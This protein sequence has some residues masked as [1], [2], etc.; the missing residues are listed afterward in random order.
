MSIKAILFDFDGTLANTLPLC[1]DAFRLSIEPLAGRAISNREIIATFGPSEE[2]TIRA[3]V[4]D[5]YDEGV[6]SYL[7]HYE[8][9]H[10]Q[11]TDIFP[12]MRDILQDLRNKGIRVGMVTGKGARSLRI[13]FGKMDL[14]KHFDVVETGSPEGVV[15][16]KAITSILE[17]WGDIAKDEVIYVGDAP[18]DIIACREAGI[19]II[20]AAWAETSEPGALLKLSPDKIFYS[21]PE[22]KQ[23]IDTAT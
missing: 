22:F 20:A 5:H 7:H 6:N 10:A 12:G 9:L 23:W 8:R 21:I 14:E 11:C 4:P 13:T 2:G 16:G 18:S 17:R 19:P 15:K 3:L 1:I